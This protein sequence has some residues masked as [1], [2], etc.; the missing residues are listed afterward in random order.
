MVFSGHENISRVV[1]FGRVTYLVCGGGGT[2]LMQP[3]TEG[4]FLNYIVV[5][6]NKDYLDYEIRK[7]FPPLWQFFTFYLWKDLAF[8]L[9]GLLN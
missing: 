1:K 6:V 4:G 9:Q 8:F 5:K 7:V 3:T 2:L